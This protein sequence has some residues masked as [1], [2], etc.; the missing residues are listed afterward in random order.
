MMVLEVNVLTNIAVFTLIKV[1]QI[2]PGRP[3][4]RWKVEIDN[5]EEPIIDRRVLLDFGDST[6]AAE[7]L[8]NKRIT[9]SE[10]FQ[11][12]LFSVPE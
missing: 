11:V 4:F 7:V 3:T 8:L 10:H 12:L 6:S 2:I 1:Y 5:A 9:H